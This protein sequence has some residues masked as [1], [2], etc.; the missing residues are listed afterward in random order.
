MRNKQ[1]TEW[2]Q[3]IDR[4]FAIIIGL[5]I[6]DKAVMALLLYIL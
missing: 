1:E 2:R 5:W 6:L 4:K 3:R